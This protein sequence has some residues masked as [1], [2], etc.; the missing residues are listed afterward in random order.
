MQCS[1]T[2]LPVGMYK[3]D[4]SSDGQSFFVAEKHC[5]TDLVKGLATPC[6]CG[7]V[8]GEVPGS[9]SQLYRYRGTF[10]G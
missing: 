1:C 2:S 9:L 3:D 5:F 10:R 6:Q 4:S 7:V 8:G